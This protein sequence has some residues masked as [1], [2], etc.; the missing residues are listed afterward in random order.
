MNKDHLDGCVDC[1]TGSNDFQIDCSLP[2]I[3]IDIDASSHQAAKR[4]NFANFA[5]QFLV[6]AEKVSRNLSSL[7]IANRI[8][9]ESN[10]PTHK[11]KRYK[12]N[13]RNDADND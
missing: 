13:C 12:R 9:S 11:N 6:V 1:L 5:L 4:L 10:N 8:Q 7:T 3:I 2:I